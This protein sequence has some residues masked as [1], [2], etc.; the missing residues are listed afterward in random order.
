MKLF[1]TRLNKNYQSELRYEIIKKTKTQPGNVLLF[2][3]VIFD[4]RQWGIRPKQNRANTKRFDQI[5]TD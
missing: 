2:D 4:K 1:S 3:F 5:I